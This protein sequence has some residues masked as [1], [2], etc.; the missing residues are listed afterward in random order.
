MERIPPSDE[1]KTIN[2][3]IAVSTF[4]TRAVSSHPGERQARIEPP[5]PYRGRTGA[6]DPSI[7]S[8][9]PRDG[10]DNDG[11]GG[12]GLRTSIIYPFSHDGRLAAQRSSSWSAGSSPRVVM[13][14]MTHHH[15]GQR[16]QQE[17]HQ[18]HQQVCTVCMLFKSMTRREYR[19]SSDRDMYLNHLQVAHGMKPKE[20]ADTDRDRKRAEGAVLRT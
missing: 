18:H 13:A 7:L 1:G 20:G 11:G 17:Q 6:C 16:Q 14:G 4:I 10:D 15:R 3:T 8:G 19:S 2:V 5:R 9:L 12:L